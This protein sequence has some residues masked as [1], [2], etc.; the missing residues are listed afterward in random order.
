MP[1]ATSFWDHP[2]ATLEKALHIRKQI[3]ALKQSVE[4]IMGGTE[5]GNPKVAKRRG[6]PAK[7]ASVEYLAPFPAADSGLG[8]LSSTPIPIV[9]PAS[10]KSG[11]GKK[12]GRKGRRSAATIA[13]MKAAQKAR[14]A[15]VRGN[16]PAA[17]PAVASPVKK[18][19][20]MSP[21]ARAKIAAAQKARWAKVKG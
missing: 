19:R 7:V 6:R 1:K 5:H 17:T 16:P 20:T 4:D 9:I 2:I 3:E 8:G 21:E 15:K 18:R 12:D 11:K 14:W 10:K 13:K